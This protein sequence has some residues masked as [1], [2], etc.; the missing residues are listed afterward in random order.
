MFSENEICEE[1]PDYYL[2]REYVTYEKDPTFAEFQNSV[3]EE[4]E[5]QKEE[6]KKKEEK[7][8]FEKL[9][10]FIGKYKVAIIVGAV[11]IMALVTGIVIIV[12]KKKE[13]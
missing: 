8:F 11:V 3:E 5:R 9:L 6:N 7:G 4:I 10:E 2:C 12:R 1:V 13:L